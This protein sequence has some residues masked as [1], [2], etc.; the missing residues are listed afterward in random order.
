MVQSLMKKIRTTFAIWDVAKIVL[1]RF[2][3]GVN[4]K[5]VNIRYMYIYFLMIIF[6]FNNDAVIVCSE[7]KVI[8]LAWFIIGAT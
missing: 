6:T 1:K 5:T 4:W 2:V 3:G 8:V 7:L